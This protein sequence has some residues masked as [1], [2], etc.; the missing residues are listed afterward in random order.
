MEVSVTGSESPVFELFSRQPQD[1]SVVVA[2]GY[3]V[4]VHVSKGHLVVEDGIGRARR[5]R[6]IPRQP[7]EVSRLVILGSAGF[8]TLEALRWCADLGIAVVNLER[9]GRLLMSA[10]GMSGKAREDAR[11]ISAQV[12]AQ[13]DPALAV[14]AARSVMVA[15]LT[16]HGDNALHVLKNDRE[17]TRI[18]ALA[19]QVAGTESLESL[20]GF[21]GVAA[22]CYWR[23]WS[24]HVHVPFPPGDLESV[25]VHWYEFK[26]RGSL[27]NPSRPG[28]N[29]TDPVNAMLN[30]AYAVA[31]SE[32]R[33][34]C[35]I[36]G[37][38]PVIGIGHGKTMRKDSLVMD[39]MEAVRPAA[40]RVVLSLLDVGHGIPYEPETGKPGYLSIRWFSESGEGICSLNAPLSH[41]IAERVTLAV[42]PEAAKHTE[43]LAQFLADSAQRGWRV[44]THSYK[45]GSTLGA[46]F[47]Q[48]KA[49][50]RVKPVVRL[51]DDT[52][53]VDLVPDTLWQHI[54]PLIPADSSQRPP[55]MRAI[56]AGII[57]HDIH[58]A[59]WRKLP[60]ALPYVAST[61]QKRYWSWQE[62]GILV[63]ILEMARTLS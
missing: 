18:Y 31:A 40:E 56:V 42:A 3:G 21:E 53:V 39:L 11:L 28:M 2:D 7:R 29:A 30:Y 5:V 55:D 48:R 1:T 20:I 57:A 14:S 34:A 23:A 13:D 62:M 35:C 4:R 26:S 63:R 38:N 32:I 15:K 6:K 54:E 10:P 46:T 19:N 16:G 50:E 9:S 37:L 47:K 61:Y 27:R 45:A 44:Q 58:H 25:P 8:V 60:K 12:R 17:A 41:M 36:M 52:S 33:I 22:K 59:A 24:Q 51:A 43:L 49:R